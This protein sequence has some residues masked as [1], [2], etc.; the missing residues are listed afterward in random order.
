MPRRLFTLLVCAAAPAATLMAQ[1]FSGSEA[2]DASVNLA[3]AQGKLPGAVLVVGHE[4]RVVYHKAY[5]KRALV[6]AP[7]AM[8][9]DTIFDLASLTK[10]VATT[11][12]LMKLFE[13]GKF[14]VERQ[15]DG[16]HPRISGR[17]ERDHNSRSDDPFLRPRARLGA[18]TA[19]NGYDTGI[20]RPLHRQTRRPAG[21]ALRLQRHQF[22]T[23]GRNGSPP[24]RQLLDPNTRAQNIFQPL[25]MK[26]TMFLPPLRC[27]RASLP[28]NDPAQRTAAARRR[29]RPD[30]AEHGRRRRPRGPV[31][32]SRRPGAIC[33]DD[34]E[35]RG[36]RRRANF[37]PADGSEIHSSRRR[38]PD[39]PILRG[40]GWDIDSPLVGES[41]RTVSHRFLR[42]HGLHWH[43]HLDRSLDRSLT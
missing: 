9:E 26:D 36:T 35:W 11:S 37:Q 40:L 2:L 41:R 42:P 28:R 12:S 33:P 29:A 43:I 17:Q 14:R 10:V 32:H 27:S 19:W 4:G 39:Q 3:I 8:T 23:A 24:E 15:D 25:G 7:E 31:L 22:H 18:G 16:L 1:T 38:P 6:P 13:Q 20:A 5:G 34:A 30:R 21:R